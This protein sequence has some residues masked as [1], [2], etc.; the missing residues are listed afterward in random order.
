MSGKIGI[1]SYCASLLLTTAPP[2]KAQQPMKIPKMDSSLLPLRRLARP[3]SR[4][5]SGATRAW[6]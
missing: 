5:S 6:L 4:L 2:A 1:L 3:A